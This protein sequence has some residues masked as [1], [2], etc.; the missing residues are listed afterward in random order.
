MSIRC[1]VWISLCSALFGCDAV[2]LRFEPSG[3]VESSGPQALCFTPEDSEPAEPDR[4][5]FIP[6]SE[7]AAFPTGCPAG[8]QCTVVRTAD[9]YRGACVAV[10]GDRLIGECCSRGEHGDDDC[11]AGSWCT[12]LG[13]GD[14][15]HGPMACRELCTDGAE[16]GSN[17]RCLRLGQTSLGV[18]TQRCEVFSNDCGS[19]GIRCAAGADTSGTHAG[20]CARYGSGGESAVCMSD[21]DCAAEFVCEGPTFE[22]AGACRWLCDAAHPCPRDL[23]CVPLGLGDPRSP[24]ICVE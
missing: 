1:P 24:R 4:P 8:E 18:C 3:G 19:P 22:S 13:I 10:W 17:E 6:G 5:P 11:V 14:P 7:C 20:Y 21:A 2:E 23:R 9:S 16:C 15:V 12:P